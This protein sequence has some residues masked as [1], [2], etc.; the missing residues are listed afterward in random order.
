MS[1]PYRKI[2]NT[3][4]GSFCCNFSSLNTSHCYKSAGCQVL[5]CKI[6]VVVRYLKTTP[7][8]GL[9][10][11]VNA[12]FPTAELPLIALL[13]NK[14]HMTADSHDYHG[15]EYKGCRKRQCYFW[16]KNTN[17]NHGMLKALH[18]ICFSMFFISIDISLHR[19]AYLYKPQS[20]TGNSRNHR[21]IF[22]VW[23]S[24]PAELVTS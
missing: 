9:L 11:Q 21:H 8:A 12:T 16:K 15:R 3:E 2:P 23:K 14:T 13:E 1:K 20:I 10:W 19:K 17:K 6:P 22:T 24:L 18:M 5:S 4:G 7:H